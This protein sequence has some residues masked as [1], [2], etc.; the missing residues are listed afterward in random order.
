MFRT[1]LTAL[2]FSEA[3][4]AAAGKAAGMARSCGARLIFFHALDY[5]LKAQGEDSPACKLSCEQAISCYRR[6]VEPMLE[7]LDDVDFQCRPAD[8][9]LEICRLAK[10]EHADLIILGC[11]QSRLSSGMALGRVDY[12]GMTILEKAPCP[13]MLVPAEPEKEAPAA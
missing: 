8:P 7:G 2:T 6:E 9:A 13:V 12:T 5:R 11:H 1:I 3:G 10:T 4:L